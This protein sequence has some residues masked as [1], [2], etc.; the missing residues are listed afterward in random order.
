MY[1]D[2]MPDIMILAQAVLQICMSQDCFTIR[3]RDIIQSKN[4]G[5]NLD[6]TASI[7]SMHI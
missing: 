3:T 5:L 4:V 1:P 7:T 2:C 6:L